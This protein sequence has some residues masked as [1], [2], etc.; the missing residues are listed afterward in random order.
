M[1]ASYHSTPHRDF[2]TSYKAGD[3]GIVRMGNTSC[4]KTVGILDIHIKTKV[5][6]TIV[7]KDVCHVLNLQMNLISGTTLDNDSS[8]LDIVPDPTQSQVT[9]DDEK[10]QDKIPDEEEVAESIE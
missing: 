5:G 4:S 7:L 10:M 9:V 6:F 8:A 1:V 2:F 3:F